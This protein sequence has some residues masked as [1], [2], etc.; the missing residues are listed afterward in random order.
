MGD[1]EYTPT[2]LCPK[3]NCIGRVV[4]IDDMILPVIIELNRKGW[5]T[6][7]CCSGHTEDCSSTYITFED[8]YPG[9]MPEGFLAEHDERMTI[10]HEYYT[11]D[12][13]EK[14]LQILN[15]NRKLLEWASKLPEVKSDRRLYRE[16]TSD[17]ELITAIKADEVT[18]YDIVYE[19]DIFVDIKER[20]YGTDVTA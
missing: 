17:M 8:R 9:S 5:R 11:R 15:V 7:Y 20:Q 10:R 6:R 12:R 14:G 19:N 3:A 13:I 4:E 18:V 16:V 1:A 2:D